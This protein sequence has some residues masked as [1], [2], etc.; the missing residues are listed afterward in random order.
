M[1]AYHNDAARHPTVIDLG[2]SRG[3]IAGKEAVAGSWGLDSTAATRL[4]EYVPQP[5][6]R[7][8]RTWGP[9]LRLFV[10]TG[11]REVVLLH[12]VLIWA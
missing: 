11:Q 1:G 9:L 8:C 5:W 10:L 3:L 4:K 12:S 6:E 7:R 2:I